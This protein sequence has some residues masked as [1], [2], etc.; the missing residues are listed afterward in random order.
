MTEI[1]THCSH[2][3]GNA[4]TNPPIGAVGFD[5]GQSEHAY[6]LADARG[7]IRSGRLSHESRSLRQWLQSLPELCGTARVALA[8]ESCCPALLALMGEFPWLE[9]YP[10][11]PAASARFRR[12]FTPSGAKD[13]VPDAQTLFELLSQHRQRLRP[14]R[15]QDPPQTRLLDGLVRL[16]RK[17]VDRRVALNHQIRAALNSFFPEALKLIGEDFSTA[18]AFDFL[19]RWPDLGSLKRSRPATLKKFFYQHGL[20]RPQSIDARVELIER[21]LALHNDLPLIEIAQLN[22]KML[23]QQIRLLAS[24]ISELDTQISTIFKEHENWHFF[25]SLPGAGAAMAPRLLCALSLLSDQSVEQM[26]RYTGVAPVIERSGTRH[27]V[28]RRWN[29]P[30]FVH[31]TLVEWAGLTVQFSSWARAYYYH[32]RASGKGRHTALRALAFKWLRVLGS[33]LRS[34]QDYDEKRYISALMRRNCPYIQPTPSLT[35]SPS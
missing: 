11:H 8:I 15:Q 16:R 31:Q 12:A 17:M 35:S 32:A 10:I 28:H 9:I 3:A 1:S 18:L 13:D 24:H 21:S 22:L 27:W 25:R 2:I 5:W 7:N 23:L 29:P 30:R 6:C 19:N 4:K 33:C 14:L 34:G 20:R 26:Q